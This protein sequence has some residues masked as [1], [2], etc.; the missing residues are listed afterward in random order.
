MANRKL[1]IQVQISVDGFI[2]GPDG[3]M[4]WMEWN[5]DE[6]IKQYVTDLTEPV[7]GILL[8][9]K[10]AEGFIPYWAGVAANPDDPQQKAG[11]KFSETPKFVFS[12]TLEKS[13]WENTVLAKGN[14]AEEVNQLKSRDGKDLIS[15]GG[16]QFVSSLIKEGLVDEFHLFVNPTALGKGL[17]IYKEIGNRQ[18]LRLIKATAF[19]CGI[20]VLHYEPKHA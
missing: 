11:K 12:K 1:K 2:A 19:N 8:G 14:L 18:S 17:S 5:W 10:L 9:R 15:Y 6:K 4:D 13:L 16:A 20:V 3:E 7:D